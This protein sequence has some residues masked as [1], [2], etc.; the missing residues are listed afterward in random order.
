MYSVL[1]FMATMAAADLRYCHANAAIAAKSEIREFL[2]FRFRR[3][4]RFFSQI[5]SKM[6]NDGGEIREFVEN[7]SILDNL[8]GFFS[9][10]VI[11]IIFNG[12][13]AFTRNWKLITGNF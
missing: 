10:L 6:A 7:F 11:I 5:W 3:F 4:R 12:S 13:A 2:P 8:N 9:I 1:L